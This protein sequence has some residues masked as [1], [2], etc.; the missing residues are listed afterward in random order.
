MTPTH[1]IVEAVT[2]AGPSIRVVGD[3]TNLQAAHTLC[4]IAMSVAPPEGPDNA[5]AIDQDGRYVIALERMN[6][7]R[8]INHLAGRQ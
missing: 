8:I 5:F 4:A 3:A 7:G 6:D 1:Y 2:W